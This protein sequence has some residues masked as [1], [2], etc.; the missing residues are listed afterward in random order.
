MIRGAMD[1]V[2]GAE[3]RQNHQKSQGSWC[4]SRIHVLSFDENSCLP[5]LEVKRKTCW[6]SKY[7]RT[8]RIYD[9]IFDY[10]SGRDPSHVPQLLGLCRTALVFSGDFFKFGARKIT[11]KQTTMWENMFQLCFTFFSQ[12]SSE[13]PSTCL[14]HQPSYS[15]MIGVLNHRSA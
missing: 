14:R 11:M 4:L 13:N 8:Y 1:D 10:F 2:F 5:F 6:F 7:T 9:S 15:Q 3:E 12:A